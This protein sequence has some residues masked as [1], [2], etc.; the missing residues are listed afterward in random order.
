MAHIVNKLGAL[1]CPE[2][3][4]VFL[5]PHAWCDYIRYVEFSDT[6]HSQKASG[7]ASFKPLIFTSAL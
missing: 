6:R 7:L 4:F 3:V 5:P 2:I 1:S